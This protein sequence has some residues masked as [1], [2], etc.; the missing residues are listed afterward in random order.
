MEETDGKSKHDRFWRQRKA[1][2]HECKT[3]SSVATKE[4]G[5]KLC[6]SPFL[7]VSYNGHMN[8][9]SPKGLLAADP[10]ADRGLG[11]WTVKKVKQ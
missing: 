1:H 7:W 6:A 9:Y 11:D 4:R 5:A 8:H 10:S 2:C 3:S